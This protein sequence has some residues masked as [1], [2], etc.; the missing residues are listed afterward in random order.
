[1]LVTDDHLS[2]FWVYL[3]LQAFVYYVEEQKSNFAKTMKT[4][5]V[6]TTQYYMFIGLIFSPLSCQ[7]KQPLPV[8][9]NISDTR[10]IEPEGGR[11]LCIQFVSLVET[12]TQW[13]V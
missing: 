9:L 11:Y 4:E 5:Q 3:G 8:V 7:L 10:A 2:S 1:M 13:L 6:Q 12:G